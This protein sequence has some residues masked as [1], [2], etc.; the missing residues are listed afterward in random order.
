VDSG[1]IA[2]Q[3][4]WSTWI[5]DLAVN[6]PTLMDALLGFSAFHLRCLNPFDQTISEASHKYMTRAISS[7]AKELREGVDE[8]NVEGLFA[9]SALITFHASAHQTFLC[10]D[11][12]ECRLPLHWFRPYQCARAVLTALWPWL[13]NTSIGQLIRRQYPQLHSLP[14][15]REPNKFNPL[16]GGPDSEEDLDTESV[17][18]Y[19]AAVICLSSIYA[20]PAYRNILRFTAM[21]SARF[22]EL[23]VGQDPRTLTIVGYYFMLLKNATHI[24][25]VHGAVEKEFK[26]VTTFLPREWWPGMDWAVKEFELIGYSKNA[27]GDS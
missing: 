25:W 27:G 9:T 19:Q 2:G 14:Q 15:R 21:V 17:E 16:L 20:S 22:V 13:Q 26:A 4:T 5:T 23:L 18:A 8:K 11:E 6:T 12:G 3:H 10:S 1:D 24:W 7:Q